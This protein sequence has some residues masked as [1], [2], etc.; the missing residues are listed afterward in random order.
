MGKRGGDMKQTPKPCPFCGGE[1]NVFQI[2]ENTPEE[3]ATHPDWRWN[4]PGKWII[5]CCGK[6]FECFGNMNHMTM[7]FTTEEEAIEAWNRR[8]KEEKNE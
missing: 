7:V 6:E 4:H 1:A 2:P 8:A 3:L 5:G